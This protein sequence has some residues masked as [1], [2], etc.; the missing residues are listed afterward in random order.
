MK[1]SKSRQIHLLQ[2]GIV[3]AQRYYDMFFADLNAFSHFLN[4]AYRFLFWMVWNV[5]QEEEITAKMTLVDWR[6]A[7]RNGFWNKSEKR[8]NSSK[9]GFQGYLQ[10]RKLSAS[11][12]R[13]P[14]AERSTSAVQSS[15]SSSTAKK[16][17]T[18]AA[19]RD[20]RS[21]MG[22]VRILNW[23]LLLMG[24][25]RIWLIVAQLMHSTMIKVKRIN[26]LNE[27]YSKHVWAKERIL[28][29]IPTSSL[30]IL[31]CP[32]AL[33]HWNWAKISLAS[34]QS[35]HAISLPQPPDH[36]EKI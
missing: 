14:P 2:Q 32:C 10:Q 33:V 20:S 17:I 6:W 28:T 13:R 1:I 12:V 8:W 23:A 24:S 26:R 34:A 31:L 7:A 9:G 18:K 21:S 25:L 16:T 15:A 3:M 29:R 11:V 36:I 4:Q 27:Q 22:M 19:H 35:S 30:L 5:T